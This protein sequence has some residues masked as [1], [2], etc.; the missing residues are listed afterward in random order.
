M[1]HTS[2]NSVT[3]EKIVALCKRRGFAFPSNEIYGGLN[4]VYDIGNLGVALKNNIRAAWIKNIEAFGIT[5]NA[6]ILFL[7]GALLGTQAMWE[8]SGHISNFHD[9]MVD[10]L[11][12]KHRYRADDINLDGAC[13]HCGNKTWSDVREFN[14]MFKT[15]LGAAASLSSTAYLRPETAQSIFIN[16]KNIYA[17]SRMKIPAGVAQ[18]GK[19]FRNEITPKQFLFR[20]REFEQMEIEWFCQGESADDF[21]KKWSE[22]RFC[23]LQNYR[24]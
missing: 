19:A 12:C 4:G 13:P 7:E 5:N 6:E 14:M 16:F 10:C 23:F 15:E 1:E 22:H 20:M 21:F 24:Y 18:I 11:T 17:S 3:L 8:A 9:P 2:N